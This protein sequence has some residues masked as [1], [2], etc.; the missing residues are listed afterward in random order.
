MLDKI[1]PEKP[2]VEAEPVIGTNWNF[3]V[4]IITVGFLLAFLVWV[5]YPA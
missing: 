1:N 3:V 4:E 2:I 5:V